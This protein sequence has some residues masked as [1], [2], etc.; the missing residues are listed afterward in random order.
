MKNWEIKKLGDVIEIRNGKNQ[1]EVLSETGQYPI[2]GS[3]GNVMGYASDY[4][5]EAGTTIIGR[6]G[7]ISKPIFIAER[8]WNVDTA[9]GL[10][11]KNDLPNKFVFYTCL[12]IDFGSMN[13]GTTIPSLVKTELLQIPLLVP[14]SVAEQRRIVAILDEAFA[15]IAQA[16]ANAEK[17]L[18]NAKELFESYLQGVFEKKGE[19]WEEKTLGEVCEISSKLIDPKKTEFQELIHVGAGNIESRKGTLIEL[20]TANEENLISG[21][22]LFDETMILYSKIRPYLM[23][24]VNCNFKGLCSADIYPLLPFKEKLNKDFL[25]HLLLTKDFTDYAILGSQ[26]AGMPKVNREHLFAFKFYLPSVKTQQTI[27][28]QLDALSLETKKLEVM[29]QQKISDLEEL[30]KSILQKAFSGELKTVNA[31][32]I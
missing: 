11:P 18:Q 27:V 19:G 32:A 1:K 14:K 30:K 10:Y 23:K 24:V 5:C 12:N 17:N 21:K 22:F 7:N 25:Y 31:V 4:I 15:A 28:R 6:K 20:R 26:R 9:F 13:R 2:L 3:G 8:F 16:K 29:Y